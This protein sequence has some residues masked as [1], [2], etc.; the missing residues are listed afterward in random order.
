MSC[1]S[2]NVHK[3]GVQYS[4]F[5][6]HGSTVYIY[7]GVWW[8]WYLLIVKDDSQLDSSGAEAVGGLWIEWQLLSRSSSKDDGSSSGLRN[9]ILPGLQDPKC[10][11]ERGR[12]GEREGEE[13]REEGRERGRKEGM[14]SEKVEVQLIHVTVHV[15]GS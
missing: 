11:L 2:C 4:C 6:I 8:V 3:Q 5:I 15:C 1:P 13:G 7:K 14:E 12:E 9:T 10:A